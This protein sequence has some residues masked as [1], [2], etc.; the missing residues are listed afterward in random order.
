MYMYIHIY[1]YIHYMYICDVIL[2]DRCIYDMYK[3]V[4][5]TCTDIENKLYTLHIQLCVCC[6]WFSDTKWTPKWINRN[7]DFPQQTVELEAAKLVGYD[8]LM[9]WISLDNHLHKSP[10]YQD[11]YKF[12]NETYGDLLYH[13]IGIN[14][15]DVKSY[16]III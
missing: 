7:C 1:I 6:T 10:P 9:G 11:G 8:P 2:K 14:C 5:N 3:Y 16:H 12:E 13:K 15:T 4:M